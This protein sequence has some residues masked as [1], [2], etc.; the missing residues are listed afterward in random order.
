MKYH[1]KVH[2]E[3]K[4]FWAECLELEGCITQG[5]SR[6]HL[7]AMMHDALAAYLNEPVSSKHIFPMPN[8]YQSGRGI[9]EVQV[10]PEIAIAMTIR[11]LRV[12]AGKSQKEMA[13]WLGMK[14]L[15][16]YQRLESSKNG[17]LQLGTMVKLKKVFP[18]FSV[19]AVLA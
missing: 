1:F 17:N 19:D 3:G 15:F 6:E 16:S 10:A 4:G 7:G 12:S 14:S 9:V 11:Q 18:E 5:D 2:K 13:D 8:H